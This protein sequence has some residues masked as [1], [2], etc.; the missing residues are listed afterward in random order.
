MTLSLVHVQPTTGTVAAL[1]ATGGVAVGGYVHHAWRGI[2]ACATQG[3][4]TN[5][6]YPD[7]LRAALSDSGS[8]G[9]ALA[10]VV[11]ADP[12]ASRRQCLVMDRQ[13]RAV[14]HSGTDNLPVVASACRP[15]VA[16]AGNMLA[17]TEV[18][19]ALLWGFLEQACVNAEAAW[20]E[21]EP[22]RYRDDYEA[23]LPE[24]LV[25]ALKAALAAGG[26]GRGTRSVA[27]RVESFSA[28]PIDLRVDWSETPAA[29]LRTLIERVREPT[30]AG[31]LASLPL[32]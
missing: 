6:W 17:G 7:T 24:M 28:A 5:P 16:A 2:G 8:A 10:Q 27:L 14:V 3:L 30:F 22:P 15:T 20:R 18:I 1:T 9:Q 31:F 13:G 29:E 23:L 26:D 25:A 11:S 4:V 12:G 19:D 21:V 32:R